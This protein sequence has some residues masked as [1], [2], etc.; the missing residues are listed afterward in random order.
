MRWLAWLGVA[1]VVGG[2]ATAAALTWGHDARAGNPSA[3]RRG[4]TMQAVHR[5]AGNPDGTT[6][7]HLG[8]Y[9]RIRARDL[10][11]GHVVRTEEC[12]FYN[13]TKPNTVA[14]ACFFKGRVLDALIYN[15]G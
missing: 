9:A 11:H 14:G 10:T 7:E 2:A 1:I 8:E 4:M 5:V 3:I 12:W 15:H 13:A 6:V